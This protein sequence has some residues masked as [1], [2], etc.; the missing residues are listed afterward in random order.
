MTFDMQAI[1]AS[2]K[3]MRRRTDLAQ[4]SRLKAKGNIKRVTI[5]DGTTSMRTRLIKHRNSQVVRIPNELW[6]DPPAKEVEIE[7]VG[8]RL[9]IRPVRASLANVLKKFAAFRPGLAEELRVI[10]ERCAALPVHDSRS[11]DEILDY[12][13]DGLPRR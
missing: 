3:K 4:G 5:V 1:I 9:V 10:G 13:D 7:R 12:D 6:F 2:K 11:A 8:D